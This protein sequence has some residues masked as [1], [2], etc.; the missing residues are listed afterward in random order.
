MNVNAPRI[1]STTVPAVPLRK[2]PAAKSA[3]SA[4]SISVAA[5]PA[6]IMPFGIQFL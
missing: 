3:S 2:V 6:K 4:P 5:A 1:T